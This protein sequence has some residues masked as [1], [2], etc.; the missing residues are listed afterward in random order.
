MELLLT[1]AHAGNH[2]NPRVATRLGGER[3]ARAALALLMSLPGTPTVYNGEE[4]AMS[5]VALRDDQV[6]DPA[7][8]RQPREL[9]PVV[10]RDPER[11]PVQWNS[12]RAAGFLPLN[13]PSEAT[14]WLP[15]AP[16]ATTN[17]VASQE[18]NATSTLTLFRV[19]TTLRRGEPALRGAPLVPLDW[20]GS[21]DVPDGVMAFARPL[22]CACGNVTQA[23]VL[24]SSNDY[25]QAPAPTPTPASPPPPPIPRFNATSFIF[26]LNMG[27]TPASVNIAAAMGRAGLGAD[28]WASA[29]TLAVDSDTVATHRGV[30]MDSTAVLVQP[31]QALILS[32]RLDPHANSTT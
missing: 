13:A 30:R 27:A 29:L 20:D 24:G 14:P 19:L 8:L 26:V 28:G 16:D 22:R 32:L 21:A 11:T 18:N 4:L 3:P 9:W 17:N 7:A 2:D 5:N 31:W 1:N 12:S 10:G 6:R 23:A 15:L 25:A